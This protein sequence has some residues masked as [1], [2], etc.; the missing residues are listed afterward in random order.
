MPT[1]SRHLALAGG[2]EMIRHKYRY[3]GVLLFV[4]C[5]MAT[6]DKQL[7]MQVAT[8]RRT[9]AEQ[10]ERMTPVMKLVSR[11]GELQ[12][13]LLMMI[14]CY[15]RVKVKYKKEPEELNRQRKIYSDL[16]YLVLHTVVLGQ[17]CK[18][19][20][21]RVRP[22]IGMD[23]WCWQGPYFNSAYHS[24]PSGHALTS[25]LFATYVWHQK[26]GKAGKW[27]V[28][29]WALA[30]AMSRFYLNRHWLSDIVVGL[31]GGFFIARAHCAH[32]TKE[33]RQ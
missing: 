28:L 19:L 4:V 11:S 24:F 7:A 33:S 15:L 6:C 30:V 20:A 9:Q 26:S 32:C 8:Y 2:Q 14:I 16:A 23:P 25:A 10:Q 29:V 17:I 27:L 31:G 12:Y 5:C 22:Y 21:G 18:L 1:F 3:L 13:P